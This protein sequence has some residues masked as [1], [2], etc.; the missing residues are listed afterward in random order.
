MKT[1]TDSRDRPQPHGTNP[2]RTERDENKLN[3]YSTPIASVAGNNIPDY[4]TFF[5]AG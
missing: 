3:F 1:L 5:F 4:K 2:S